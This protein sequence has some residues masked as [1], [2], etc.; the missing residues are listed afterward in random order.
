MDRKAMA[1]RSI[2]LVDNEKLIRN[3]FGRELREEGFA[4]TT[5]ANGSEAVDELAK[6]K[7]DLVI[8][9]LMTPDADG[10]D[11]LKAVKKIVPQTAVIVLASYGNMRSVTEALHLGADDFALKPCDV[12]ELVFRIRRCLER[13]SLLQMLALQG[14]L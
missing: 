12:E 3:S 4:V 7:Y 13:Q 8:T 6:K 11:V 2:L 1:E 5:V 10:F 14:R 9:D